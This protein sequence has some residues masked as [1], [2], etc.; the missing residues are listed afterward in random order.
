MKLRSSILHINSVSQ[1]TWELQVEMYLLYLRTSEVWLSFCRFLRSSRFLDKTFKIL[2][3]RISW[4]YDKRLGRWCGFK[5]WHC[6][7]IRHPSL[8]KRIEM[9]QGTSALSP[10]NHLTRLLDAEYFVE[11]IRRESCKFY[12]FFLLL[13]KELLRDLQVARIIWKCVLERLICYLK[14]SLNSC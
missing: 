11:F 12:I 6:L 1:E 7:H 10:F 9:V 5:D 14:L 3:H 2:L 13:L 8:M 4:K